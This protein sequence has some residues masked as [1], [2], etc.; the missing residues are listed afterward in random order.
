MKNFPKVSPF[1]VSILYYF[2][3]FVK[4]EPSKK[5]R[6][7]MLDVTTN[8]LGYNLFLLNHNGYWK[9]SNNISFCLDQFFKLNSHLISHISYQSFSFFFFF[10]GSPG[11]LLDAMFFLLCIIPLIIA[12]VQIVVWAFYPLKR[13]KK[14]QD[15]SKI[16]I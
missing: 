15:I 11:Q 16:L 13:P 8:N 10:S 5:L 12:M 6:H 4:F 3:C 14:A 2:L 9:L 1:H 7:N